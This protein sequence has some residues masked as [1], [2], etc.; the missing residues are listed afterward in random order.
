MITRSP[1]A[2]SINQFC[3]D[4]AISR[5]TFYNLLKRG[6]GPAVMKV[7][8]RTLVSAESAAAWRRRMENAACLDEA[9]RTNEHRVFPARTTTIL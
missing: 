2:S 9:A 7:G 3:R 8:K 1:C 4:H 5:S 6:V